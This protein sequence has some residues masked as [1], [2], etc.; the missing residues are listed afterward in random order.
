MNEITVGT[1]FGLGFMLLVTAVTVVVIWQVAVSIRAR[2]AVSRE[3]EYR[4]LADQA[5][6]TQET[7]QRQLAEL[8]D[9]MA[10]IQAR[11][12]SLERVLKEVE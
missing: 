3:R 5:I 10:D 11:M 4:R 6:A 1:L 9:R 8:N 12:A 7:A 2:A